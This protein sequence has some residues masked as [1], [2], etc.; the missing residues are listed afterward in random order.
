SFR[1][2]FARRQ[3]IS[4]GDVAQIIELVRRKRQHVGRLVAPAE[5]RVQ[6]AELSVGGEKYGERSGRPGTSARVSRECRA[7]DLRAGFAPAGVL[8]EQR[9]FGGL[10][11]ML[12]RRPPGSGGKPGGASA[13]L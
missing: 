10:H 4:D 1:D 6:G 11:G 2:R 12:L 5:I 7:L 8:D 3:A 13:P 9:D